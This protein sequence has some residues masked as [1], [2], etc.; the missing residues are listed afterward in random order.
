MSPLKKKHANAVTPPAKKR[1][2]DAM[3]SG[4]TPASPAS[5]SS[6]STSASHN[7][8]PSTASSSPSTQTDDKNGKSAGPP[9]LLHSKLPE[10]FVALLEARAEFLKHRTLDDSEHQGTPTTDG[11]EKLAE[12]TRAWVSELRA[13][14]PPAYQVAQVPFPEHCKSFLTALQ[15]FRLL[16]VHTLL[17]TVCIWDA[18]AGRKIRLLSY[19]IYLAMYRSEIDSSDRVSWFTT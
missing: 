2:S 5:S 19:L 15:I 13:L 1:K 16:A 3:L 7:G 11:K 18:R 9:P 6:T 4:H 8:S 17:E 14:V 10:L 12:L